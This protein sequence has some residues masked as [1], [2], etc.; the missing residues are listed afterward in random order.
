MLHDLECL[1]DVLKLLAV[2]N[3]LVDLQLPCHVVI[4]QAR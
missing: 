4:N 2:R 1:V 3:E